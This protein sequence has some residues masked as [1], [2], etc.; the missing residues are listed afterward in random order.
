MRQQK[1][2]HIINISSLFGYLAS[3]PGFGLYGS[4]K[5]AVVG[6]SEG[7]ALEVNPLGIHVTSLAPGLFSTDFLSGDSYVP[8]TNVLEAY[9]TTVGKVRGAAGQI[10]GNQPGD[11]AKLAQVVIQLAYSQKPPVHLPVGKDAIESFRTKVATMEAEVKAWESIS[12]H[13]DRQL[14]AVS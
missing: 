5:F 14:Q 4:T 6:I 13:T 1:S 11:P 7:L 10:H 12:G 9:N 8:G 2:G 3:V